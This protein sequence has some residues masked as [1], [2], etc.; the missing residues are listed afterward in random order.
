MLKTAK[1]MLVLAVFLPAG[2]QGGAD[3]P[4]DEADA[5]AAD[6]LAP[7]GP[8]DRIAVW[9]GFS[10]PESGR[11]DPAQD[12]WF[13]GNF[14]GEGGA[15]DANGFVSRIS[16]ETGEIEALRFAEGSAAYPPHAPRGMF[17]TGDTLWVADIDGVHRLRARFLERRRG[18]R[19]RRDLCDRYRAFRCLQDHGA[20]HHGSALRRGAG[21]PQWNHLGSCPRSAGHRALGARVSRQR[22]AT[23]WTC[24]GDRALADT[25]PSRRSGALRPATRHCQPIGLLPPRHGRRRIPLGHQDGRKAGRHRH[26]HEA[27]NGGRSIHLFEPRRRLPAPAPLK[28]G[29]A[30]KGGFRGIR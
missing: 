25:R 6:E 1:F 28:R 22:L 23:R 17:I 18:R 30:P 2:C 4:G 20:G 26:R 9:E 16:A 10:G 15:R 27:P 3:R 21:Q 5:A 19:G 29:T 8:A 24:A 11:Y 14:N 7:Q 13:V 12:V